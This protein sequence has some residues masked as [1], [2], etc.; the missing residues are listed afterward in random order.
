MLFEA[1]RLAE[2]D[3]SI[4][5]QGE[6]V[7][8]LMLLGPWLLLMLFFVKK[9]NLLG[10]L[11]VAILMFASELVAY[12]TTFIAPGSSTSALIYAVKP[13]YQVLLIIPFGLLVGKAITFLEK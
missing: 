4:D 8:F 2:P 1:D 7:A 13:V 11:I 3:G 10:I 6:I 5:M 12:Y 9:F